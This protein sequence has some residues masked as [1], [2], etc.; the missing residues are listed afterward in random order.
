MIQ[1]ANAGDTDVTD[2]EKKILRDKRDAGTTVIEICDKNKRTER[3][4]EDENRFEGDTGGGTLQQTQLRQSNV[5]TR[6][7]Y[8]FC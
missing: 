5:C 6:Q 3:N 8:F 4:C 7:C 1:P 2:L